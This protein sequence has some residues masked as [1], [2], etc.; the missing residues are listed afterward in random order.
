[1]LEE[2]H[3]KHWEK[4]VQNIATSVRDIS[5]AKMADQGLRRRGMGDNLREVGK[6]QIR[7]YKA[8]IRRLDGVEQEPVLI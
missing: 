4:Q 3:S 7:Y 5:R 6:G 2:A 8:K 1:M